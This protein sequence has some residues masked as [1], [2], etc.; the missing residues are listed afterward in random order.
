MNKNE[1]K[2]ELFQTHPT[3]PTHTHIMSDMSELFVQ[4]QHAQTTVYSKHTC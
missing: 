1:R 3:D 2:E 4:S